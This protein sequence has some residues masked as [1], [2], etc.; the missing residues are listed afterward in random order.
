MTQLKALAKI[1]TV[2][3]F[4]E[5]GARNE[6]K[7]EGVAEIRDESSMKGVRVVIEV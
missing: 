7:L 1:Y 6:K 3:S 4:A 2:N 5:L